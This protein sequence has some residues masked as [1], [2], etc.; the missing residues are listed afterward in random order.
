[1]R[2]ERAVITFEPRNAANCLDLAMKFVGEHLREIL[3]LWIVVAFPS[4]ALVYVLSR[5]YLWDLRVA[6]I[7]AF[8]AT[9]PLGVL[10]SLIS[11]PAMFGAP[12]SFRSLFMNLRRNGAS[13]LGKG[14]LL[15]LAEGVGLVLCVVPG[16]WIMLRTGFFIEQAWFGSEQSERDANRANRL[17]QAAGGDLL[18]RACAIVSF[19]ALLV[20]VVFFLVDYAAD[21][22]FGFPILVG[23]IAESLPLGEG[24][25][26]SGFDPS[27]VLSDMFYLGWNDPRVLTT[28]TGVVLLVYTIG[29]LAWF[30]CYVDVQV[31]QDLWDVQLEFTRHASRLEKE[32]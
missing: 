21:I 1:M 26:G 22:L 2:I 5:W 16:A 11:L 29:R 28:L 7:I 23:R 10:L 14:V 18:M 8:L 30:F 27:A 4:C 9:S 17:L 25:G 6:A 3:I 24:F 31:R 15:R 20:V 13:L 32:Q 12:F 19:C